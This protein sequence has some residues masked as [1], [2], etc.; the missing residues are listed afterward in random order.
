MTG[1]IEKV[2]TNLRWKEDMLITNHFGERVWL[3]PCYNTKGK[4]IGITD[5]CF[6]DNPCSKHKVED[7][8]TS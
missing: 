7:N 1:F 5:C 2:L 6:E 8:E 4:R 3:G